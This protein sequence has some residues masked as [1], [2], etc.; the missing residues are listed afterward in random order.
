MVSEVGILMWHFP[1]GSW[2]CY[3]NFDI[4]HIKGKENKAADAINKRVLKR[5][6][7]TISM[8]M[9]YLKD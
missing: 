3:N 1:T 9:T 8:Y 7:T 5:H 6:A 2:G 4:K